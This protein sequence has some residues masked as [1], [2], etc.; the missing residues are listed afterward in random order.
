MPGMPSDSL[1]GQ[2]LQ[3][4]IEATD[5]LAAARAR[6]EEAV[7]DAYAQSGLSARLVS[8]AASCSPQTVCN[9][10]RRHGWTKSNVND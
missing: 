5:E 7:V 2:G 1:K 3:L 4:V 6:W 10:A 9:L 8:Y